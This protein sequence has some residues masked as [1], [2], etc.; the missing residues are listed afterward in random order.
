MAP[1]GHGAAG[2]SDRARTVGSTLIAL[3]I[4]VGFALGSVFVRS[5]TGDVPWIVIAA[6]VVGVGAA[7]AALVN[8]RAERTAL[9]GL[10][11]VV[12][13]VIPSGF[14]WVPN[15]LALV[16]GVWLLVR[17]GVW[18]IRHRGPASAV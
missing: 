18:R 7:W 9:A 16:G 1:S 8:L 13:A 10:L 11:L 15:L 17:A 5:T 14:A 4:G 12:S 2:L 3:W 6:V